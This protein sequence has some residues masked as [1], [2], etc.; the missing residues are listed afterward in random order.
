MDHEYLS[1][2]GHREFNELTQ[3]L[4][5]GNDSPLMLS[6]RLY[7]IQGISGTGSLKL[8][9]DFISKFLRSSTVYLPNV[10][11]NGHESIL[12]ATS[13]KYSTYRYLDSTGIALDFEGLCQ[14]LISVPDRSIILFHSCAHNPSGVNQGFVKYF[15][16]LK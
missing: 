2:D 14:D 9:F 11:W 16:F 5:F 3:K 1:Q 6:G 15:D 4:M 13:L 8:G 7:T 12:E 10:T